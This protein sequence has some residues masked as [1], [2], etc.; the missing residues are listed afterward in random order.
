MSGRI[1][2]VDDEPDVQRLLSFNLQRAGFE[3]HTASTGADALMAAARDIP[4]VIILDL[5]LPDL[6]GVEICRQIRQDDSL[7]RVGVLMLTALSSDEQRVEGLTAGADDYV[8]KP[9]NVEEIILR[10]RAITRRMGERE[11]ASQKSSSEVLRC[12]PLTVNP[13]T[14]DVRV[15][16]KTVNLRPLEYKLLSLLVGAPGKVFSREELLEQ[17]WEMDAK[18]ASNP[19]LV[20]VHIRRLRQNLGKASS[21]VETVPGFGYRAKTD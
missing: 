9:F 12:G 7:A 21:V 5:M 13:V 8:V 19:R 6:S 1:L 17:V 16:D 2:V 15:D 14:H 10:V 11:Q 4:D 3:V 18:A 20:D